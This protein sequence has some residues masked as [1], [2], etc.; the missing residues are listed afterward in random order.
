LSHLYCTKVIF[1]P[2]Q[3]RDKHTIIGK[4]LKKRAGPFCRRCLWWST[5]RVIGSCSSSWRRPG[6]SRQA[7]QLRSLSRE[8]RAARCEKRHF[9]R[10]LDIKR[11]FYQDRLGT[12]IGKAEKR[13]AVFL[14]GEDAPWRVIKGLYQEND[15]HPRLDV[16][17]QGMRTGSF[18]PFI[19]KCGLFTKT[20][21]GRT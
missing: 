12:N 5:Y 21:S 6:A 3:A 15:R 8:R 20:G 18:E 13:V 4:A 11:S 10:R 16:A 14:G 2:R 1:L 7:R 19:Y 17:F 9:L